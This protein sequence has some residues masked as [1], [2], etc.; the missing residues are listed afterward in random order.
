MNTQ[1]Y[2]KKILTEKLVGNDLNLI[3]NITSFLPQYK[4]EK[5]VRCDYR[6]YQLEKYGWV[7]DGNNSAQQLTEF[8]FPDIDITLFTIAHVTNWID[9]DDIIE[10]S[11]MD[12]E[13]YQDGDIKSAGDLQEFY[14]DDFELFYR[15]SYIVK[16]YEHHQKII[17]HR[18]YL[19]EFLR[20]IEDL[21]IDEVSSD[22]ESIDI[23]LTVPLSSDSDS[24]ISDFSSSDED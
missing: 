4:Y 1:K 6:D 7:N 3:K 18:K 14:Y 12:I 16:I 21:N 23:N 22:N 9:I 8:Y 20:R 11:L 10:G 2:L 5:N 17:K 24:D 19:E 13:C 15:Y